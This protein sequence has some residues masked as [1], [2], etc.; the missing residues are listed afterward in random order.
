[1]L[2]GSSLASAFPD[3]SELSEVIGVTDLGGLEESEPPV[4]NL[5]WE[6]LGSDFLPRGASR[7]TRH[8][9]FSD[10]NESRTNLYQDLIVDWKS[11]A[12]RSYA[13]I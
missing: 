2:R 13:R 4:K 6:S 1:M 9:E 10:E 5:G 8:V 3:F 12:R 11:D 7:L